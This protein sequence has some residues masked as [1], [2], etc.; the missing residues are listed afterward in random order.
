MLKKAIFYL[1]NPGYIVYRFKSFFKNDLKNVK[2]KDDFDWDLY[3][4]HYKAELEQMKSENLSI[5]KNNDYSFIKNKL[6]CNIKKGLVLH[7]NHHVLYETLLILNPQNLIEFGC[8]GGDHLRNINTLNSQIILNAFDRS[9]N[10]IEL[11]KQRH[12][13]LNANIK[14]QN[15]TEIFGINSNYD[16]SYS[17]A[18]IMHIKDGHLQALEN[19]FNVAK[20][21]VVLM[22]NWLEHDFYDDIQML[23][24]QKRINWESLYL[25]INNYQSST[26]LIASKTKLYNFKE[27]TNKSDLF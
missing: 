25:Y 6:I 4:I 24:I 2:F 9:P 7:T 3:T 8:G 10:Q 27:L 12:P 13:N 1:S 18:V 23:F 15:I 20:S 21:Q 22:E 17:Q 16:I 19:M 5:I 26:I 14:I 11:L